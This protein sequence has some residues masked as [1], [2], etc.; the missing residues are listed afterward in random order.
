MTR[1]DAIGHFENWA[2]DPPIPV[3]TY[4]APTLHY[5]HSGRIANVSFADGHVEQSRTSSLRQPYGVPTGRPPEVTGNPVD[6]IQWFDQQN[7][8]FYGFDNSAYN[9]SADPNASK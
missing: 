2:L 8:G 5:R 9:P 3:R 6:G 7:L 1:R 4:V